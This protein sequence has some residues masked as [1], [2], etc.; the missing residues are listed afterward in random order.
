MVLVTLTVW[1]AFEAVQIS[2]DGRS[3]LRLRAHLVYAALFSAS[4]FFQEETILLF[5]IVVGGMVLWR[6]WRYLLQWPVLAGQAVVVAALLLRL[7]VE[8]SGQPGYFGAVQTH[9]PYIG[10][11]LETR[12]DT[13]ISYGQLFLTPGRL[14]WSVGMLLAISTALASLSRVGWRLTSVSGADQATLYFSLHL[15]CVL[16]FM[17][18]VVGYGWRDVR[19]LLMIQPLWLLVGSA[20][21]TAL[22]DRL[23]SRPAMRWFLVAVLAA[24]LAWFIWPAAHRTAYRQIESYDS[25]LA[26]LA[27]HTGPQDVVMSPQPAACAVGLGRACDYYARGRG[28][29]PY[30]IERRGQLLDRWTGAPL[31]QD[32]QQLAAVVRSSPRVWMLAD[33]ERLAARY[34]TDFVL[35]LME[36]FDPEYEE[37]G[38]LVLK[39]EGWKEQPPYTE[40]MQPERSI[41]MGPLSLT[42]WEH[43]ETSAGD[44][45]HVVLYW[46]RPTA[47]D[48]QINTS[49]QLVGPA[50]E[51]VAQ[52][53][54]PP[55]R[56]LVPTED[57]RDV[58]LPDTK[59]LLIPEDAPHGRYRLEVVAY[60]VKTRTP[61]A[62]PVPF[63]WFRIGPEP[64]PGQ[65][66]TDVRWDNGIVLQ[67]MDGVQEALSSGG[68][69]P[70]RLLWTSGER[71][72][73]N[74][75]SFIHVLGE[76]GQIVAQ[77]DQVPSAGF[78]PPTAWVPGDVIVDYRTLSLPDT[79]PAGTYTAIIGIYDP[80]TA[81]RVSLAEGG[82]VAPLARWRVD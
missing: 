62:Q 43:T 41:Q 30:V 10:F 39:A 69:L 49:V 38:V 45:L 68:E 64:E 79:L 20:G 63:A 78:Y 17:L 57:F 82:D 70:L 44:D 2:N 74:Y 60:D 59:T 5:P 53:D 15:G 61:F 55:V 48:R 58:P 65:Q 40:G 66:V 7:A 71:V 25:S 22:M 42:A 35:T 54:G 23:T 11:F 33:S 18:T 24:L 80:D 32:E 16:L 47:Y 3:G 4:L 12:I 27:A 46:A 1:A 50:G 52:S 37:R 21:L 51:R 73:V 81:E 28:H 8:L 67:S 31:L 56:G 19:S 6:G 9:K 34:E 75:V 13:W 36:Q 29:E 26:Y 14:A 72:P 77:N 76:E